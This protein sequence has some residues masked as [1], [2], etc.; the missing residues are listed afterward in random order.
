MRTNHHAAFYYALKQAVLLFSLCLLPIQATAEG[1]EQQL[2]IQQRLEH[3]HFGSEDTIGSDTLYAA[4]LL[5]DL[6]QANQF[7]LIWTRQDT[8][9]QLIAAIRECFQEGFIPD[10][11][12]LQAIITSGKILEMYPSFDRQVE[13]DLLLSDALMLLGSH[14]S[15]G[16]VEPGRVKERLNLEMP[17]LHSSLPYSY[18]DA[19]KSGTLN[20]MLG[21]L[22]P[23]HQVYADLKFAL[24]KYREIAD[25][26]GW[27][28]VPPGPT[29]KPGM[30]DDR[31]IALRTRLIITG[32]LSQCGSDPSLFDADLSTA[33]KSFQTQH[34]MEA[35][36]IPGKTTLFEMNR[37]VTERISQIRVDLERT[38]WVL[39]NL[40]SSYLIVD[41]AGFLV[42]Y[43]QN[44]NVIWSSKVIVGQP[45]HQT[46]I[47]RSAV[48]YLVLD[49]TW[50]VPSNIAQ[51]E[52]IPEIVKNQYYL[53]KH[54]LRVL[55][56]SGEEIDPSTIHWKQY[57]D[58]TFPYTLRQDPGKDNSLGLIKFIFPNL[59]QVY[60]HD[61]PSKMLF[62]RTKRAFSHGCIRTQNPLEL[63]K[64]VI[65]NDIGNPINSEKFDQI[66][67]SGKTT[68]VPLI[69]PLPIFLLYL[70]TSIHNLDVWFKPDLYSHNQDVQVALDDPPPHLERQIMQVTETKEQLPPLVEQI[71][72]Q[73]D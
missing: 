43:Y 18:L 34:S 47:F 42:D 65:A 61:T 15:Y 49:P 45:V 55:S 71:T 4:D 62:D 24:G 16:K 58:K 66:L 19:I 50:T 28:S 29:L 53:I 20:T 33:I 54:H 27:P 21:N 60:L 40:P 11:Y 39:H 44:G 7:Q 17:A 37:S 31:V 70:T 57:W 5:L 13:Y 35:D 56:S 23:A 38:R 6:Y 48:T 2:F 72:S 12:H 32:E 52:I 69:Q 51:K 46:P 63:G 73:I 64:L 10:D 59:H 30:H 36:G 41:I 68:T 9:D 67:A 1:G 8:I 14:K 26:G 25:N 22:S 3:L